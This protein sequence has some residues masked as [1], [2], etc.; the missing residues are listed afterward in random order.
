MQRTSFIDAQ[1]FGY[2]DS[3]YRFVNF[4]PEIKDTINYLGKNYSNPGLPQMPFHEL[5]K[6]LSKNNLIIPTMALLD[7]NDVLMDAV[8]FYLPP[9][10]L[11][12]ILFF[13]GED[14]YKT[15]T[16]AEYIKN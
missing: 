14:I 13:Y 2:A 3:T 12:K 6:M 1:V 16:W 11:K 8:P 9:A 7:E 4:N 5:S 10:I 15:K